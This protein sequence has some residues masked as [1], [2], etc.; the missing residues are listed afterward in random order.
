[1]SKLVNR[2]VDYPEDFARPIEPIPVF[3]SELFKYSVI[4]ELSDQSVSRTVFDIQP[5][6][7]CVNVKIRVFEEPHDQFED[8]LRPLA[9]VAVLIILTEVD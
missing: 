7:G 4:F 3:P 2:L 5:L 1:M 9:L 8:V 6:G